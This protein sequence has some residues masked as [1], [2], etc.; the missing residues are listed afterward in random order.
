[1]TAEFGWQ[2]YGGGG[3]LMAGFWRHTWIGAVSVVSETNGEVIYLQPQQCLCF[4]CALVLAEQFH[5]Y[6]VFRL[7]RMTLTE[8]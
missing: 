5:G 6:T 7:H 1:M 8:I 4:F 3:V 2:G